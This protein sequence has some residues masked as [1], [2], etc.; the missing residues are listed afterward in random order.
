MKRNKKSSILGARSLRQKATNTEA[1]LWKYL[2]N[3]GMIGVKFRRQHPIKGFVLDFYCP[4]FKLAIEID[5]KIHDNQKEQDRERQNIIEK[6][7]ITFL[8]FKNTDIMNNIDNVLRTIKR[9][10][11]FSPDNLTVTP[12]PLSTLWRGD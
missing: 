3:K 1:L 2:S 10:L 9:R 6:T 11:D 12:V 8:R 4:Q 7:G 5:G